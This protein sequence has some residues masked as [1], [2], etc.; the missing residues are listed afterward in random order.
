ME[1]EVPSGM[2]TTEERAVTFSPSR[3]NLVW[4]ASLLI[5]LSC[6]TCAEGKVG[7]RWGWQGEE[8]HFQ[9]KALNSGLLFCPGKTAAVAQKPVYQLAADS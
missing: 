4:F 9:G 3:I 6:A 1:P 2:A 5:S 8:D 7:M